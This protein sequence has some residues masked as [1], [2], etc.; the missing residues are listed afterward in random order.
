MKIKPSRGRRG[1]AVLVKFSAATPVKGA[2]TKKVAIAEKKRSAG[3]AGRRFTE[4]QRPECDDEENPS[5]HAAQ[6]FRFKSSLS[7]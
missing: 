7:R 4:L 3:P 2:R 6:R 1:I 5:V